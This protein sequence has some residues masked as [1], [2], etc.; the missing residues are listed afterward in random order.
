MKGFR[1]ISDDDRWA[2]AFYVAMLGGDP[3]RTA[4]GEK[5]WSAGRGKSEAGNLRA[6]A[7]LTEADVTQRYGSEIAS[8]FLWLRANPA[9]LDSS[10]PSP[11]AYARSVLA[12]SVTAYRAGR[13]AEAQRL[14]LGA[15][16]EG[17]ELAEA[18]LDT[19]DRNLRQ[20][21]EAQMLGYRE[22]LRKNAPVEQVAAAAQHID[23]LLEASAKALGRDSL[24]PGTAA[25]SA[26]FVIVREG[27]EALLVITAIVAFLLKTGRRDALRWIHAGWISALVLGL[28]TW[29][30]ASSL[31][32]V[33]GAT[34]ELTE[35]LTAL[36]AAAILLYVGF[37][38]HARSH[39]AAWKAFVQDHVQ[40]ALQRGTL[41]ALAGVSFLAVYREAFETVLFIQALWQQSE[42]NAQHAVLAG[43]GGGAAALAVIAWLMLR[44]GVRLPIGPFFTVCSIFMA[45]LAVVF[46]GHGIKALQEADVIAAS[47]VP[48]FSVSALGIYPT[49]QTIAGQLVVLLI[50]V[51]L[52][53]W[54]NGRS[55]RRVTGSSRADALD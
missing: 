5:L 7:T 21:V 6:L 9:V 4:A 30:V 28:V 8:V 54:S 27:L 34:R 16:L 48:G 2:L 33:S 38:L 13:Q 46:T 1:E 25:M 15:Y 49:L 11:I 37:W 14:A 24:T 19:V 36:F 47:P 32:R 50:I 45:L 42:G 12:D 35:G 53:L 41:W 43:L 3:A 20:E 51:V 10:Q 29:F 55:A 39:A 22:L 23:E 17:F 18:S 44:Y 26:F 31:I 52:F 40:G